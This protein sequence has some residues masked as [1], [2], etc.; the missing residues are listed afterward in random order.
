MNG[1][2]LPRSSLEFLEINLD[3]VL[4]RV[5]DP[6]NI[7]QSIC[8]VARERSD[9]IVADVESMVDSDP[10]FSLYSWLKKKNVK[11]THLSALIS[12]YAGW[13][14]ELLEALIGKDSQLKEAYHYMTKDE[15][16]KRAEFIERLI[17]DAERYISEKKR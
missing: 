14:D 10:N 17:T 16:R 13:Y 12:R 7:E 4:E 2:D 3:I 15:L 1:T 8:D 5:P 11:P 9:V 6:V